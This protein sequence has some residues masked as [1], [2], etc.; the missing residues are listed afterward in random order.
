[1]G[2]PGRSPGESPPR[3]SLDGNPVIPVRQ[4]AFTID[5]PVCSPTVTLLSP[6]TFCT[7]C[8]GGMALLR[9]KRPSREFLQLISG[10][11]RCESNGR[12]RSSRFVITEGERGIERVHDS[13]RPHSSP[14]STYRTAGKYRRHCTGRVVRWRIDKG[15]R[16][17]DFER[18]ISGSQTRFTAALGRRNGSTRRTTF[19]LARA[20]RPFESTLIEFIRGVDAERSVEFDSGVGDEPFR[21]VESVGGFV[22]STKP[23][24]VSESRCFLRN[25]GIPLQCLHRLTTYR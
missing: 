23:L 21:A 9:P 12:K 6:A 2:K 20:W 1:M 5:T 25:H 11:A 14:S 19:A 8:K 3:C 16:R 13:G 10:R 4:V 24:S 15:G 22:R 7:A 17:F 18:S